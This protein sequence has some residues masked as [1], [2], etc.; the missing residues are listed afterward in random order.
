MHHTNDSSLSVAE[1]TVII[2][3]LVSYVK[4]M[5]SMVEEME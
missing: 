5:M 2:P 4:T 3:H 1:K